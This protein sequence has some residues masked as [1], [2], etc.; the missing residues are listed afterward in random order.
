MALLNNSAVNTPPMQM[1]TRHH[2]IQLH[3]R[4]TAAVIAGAAE[5]KMYEETGMTAN[6][7]LHPAK[8][9]VKFCS[10]RPP[11]LGADCPDSRPVTGIGGRLVVSGNII[12][13][14]PWALRLCEELLFLG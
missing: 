6:A 10:P 12:A 3:S 14:V 1:T 2:S 4:A 13:G 5:E 7:A 8:G 9:F 11:A